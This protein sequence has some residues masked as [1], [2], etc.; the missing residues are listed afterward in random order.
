MLEFRC[1]STLIPSALIA[2]TVGLGGCGQRYEYTASNTDKSVAET[3]G[4]HKT[5]TS[6]KKSGTDKLLEWISDSTSTTVKG[7]PQ[8]FEEVV[9]HAERALN[10]KHF[11]EAIQYATYA[12]D[13]RPD[14]VEGYYDRARARFELDTEQQLLAI[15]DLEMVAKIQP[16]NSNAFFM[17]ATVY[18][19]AGELSKALEAINKAI[20]INPKDVDYFYLRAFLLDALNRKNDALADLS[21]LIK[22][23][24]YRGYSVRAKFFQ[25]KGQDEEALRDLAK[26]L[27]LSMP[28]FDMGTSE[29]LKLRA[30]ILSKHGRYEEA[31]KDLTAVIDKDKDGSGEGENAMRLRGNEFAAIGDY[32]NAIRGSYSRVIKSS[33][34]YAKSSFEAR[35]NAYKKLGKLKLAEADFARAATLKELPVEE[36]IY[37]LQ[38]RVN[39]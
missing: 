22:M 18:Q 33:P 28:H 19:T 39:P 20:K 10:D 12:I 30:G 34:D 4:K 29:L 8:S 9:S 24:P 15:P 25:S 3:S 36:P 6:P 31:I 2:L 13:K 23:D 14:R 37:H 1:R 11:E 26:A 38:P 16:S 35:G 7:R 21:T 27:Q 5:R 17:L 32:E